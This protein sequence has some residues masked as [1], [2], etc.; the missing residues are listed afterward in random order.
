MTSLKVIGSSYY[1]QVA[2]FYGFP[3][4]QVYIREIIYELLSL[5]K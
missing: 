3:M 1:Q 2:D 4:L 5:A